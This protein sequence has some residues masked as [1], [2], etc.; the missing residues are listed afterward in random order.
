MLL[1]SLDKNTTVKFKEVTTSTRSK[2]Q[3]TTWV[4][5]SIMEVNEETDLCASWKNVQEVSIAI[6][7]IR[8]ETPS[9]KGKQVYSSD[10]ITVMML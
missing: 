6:D 8:V 1:K 4:V 9:L 5:K 2:K 3:E 10:Q 7:P